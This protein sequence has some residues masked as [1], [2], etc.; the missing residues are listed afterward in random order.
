MANTLAT[1]EASPRTLQLQSSTSPA[2]SHHGE[3][4]ATPPTLESQSRCSP[5]TEHCE[6]CSSVKPRLELFQR[7]DPQ[8][9]PASRQLASP[10]ALELDGTT[11][12][13]YLKGLASPQMA[14]KHSL[15]SQH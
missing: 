15:Y 2:P 9:S 13:S 1:E 5:S 3:P 12:H 6:L 14:T 11:T 10:K 8:D 7:S 4:S